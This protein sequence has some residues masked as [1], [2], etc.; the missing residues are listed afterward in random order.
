MASQSLW[1]SVGK[2]KGKNIFVHSKNPD[3]TISVKRSSGLINSF[4][5]LIDDSVLSLLEKHPT[6][7]HVTVFYKGKEIDSFPVPEDALGNV[8]IF[9]WKQYS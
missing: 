4:L 1:K 7:G 2:S 9:Q 3:Y 6:Y 8:L 5:S